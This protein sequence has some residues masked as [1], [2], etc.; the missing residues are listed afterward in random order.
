MGNV[1]WL[2]WRGYSAKKRISLFGWTDGFAFP[3]RFYERVPYCIESYSHFRAIDSDHRLA[4]QQQLLEQNEHSVMSAIYAGVMKHEEMQEL[5]T[6]LN[7][8]LKTIVKLMQLTTKDNLDG[9]EMTQLCNALPADVARYLRTALQTSLYYYANGSKRKV[10]EKILQQPLYFE[11][12]IDVL[13]SGLNKM[14]AEFQVRYSTPYPHLLDYMSASYANVVPWLFDKFSLKHETFSTRRREMLN[15]CMD[16]FAALGPDVPAK[17]VVDAWAYLNN[18]GAN[19]HPTSEEFNADY[20]VFDEMNRKQNPYE[21]A[22]R[23][24]RI[25]MFN[26]PPLNLMDPDNEL[27]DTVNSEKLEW[28]DELGWE[29]ML[30]A[31]LNGQIFIA[32]APS[33]DIVN[34]KALYSVVPAVAK[35]LYGIDMTLPVV[36]AIPCWDIEDSRKPDEKV[37]A[38][39]KA[40]KNKS[41]LAHRYLEGGMGI[42]VGHSVSQEEW[43]S[44]IDTFVVDRPYLYV[45]RSYFAM[46]PDMSLRLLACCSLPDYLTDSS[47]TKV[48]LSD[49]AYGRLTTQPPL[50]TDNHRSFL[51][52]PAAPTAPAPRY[53]ME[54]V[55]DAGIR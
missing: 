46:D 53:E 10:F 55:E 26:Q 13:T 2:S 42:R 52:F 37:L 19:L 5:K 3:S 17:V 48:E 7:V 44:F 30:D 49:T 35:A 28:Y 32:N 39:L 24:K 54:L 23:G 18:S 50:A 41:V 40:N 51:V 33:S 34:D 12:G 43:E 36:D 15:E 9:E 11:C 29:G 20:L 16:R 8:A 31:Y 4:L 6:Q 1:E 27:F 45:V 25:S 14:L 22:Y 38:E 21:K 47:Q